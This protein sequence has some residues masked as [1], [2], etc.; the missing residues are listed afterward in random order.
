VKPVRTLSEMIGLTDDRITRI[1]DEGEIIGMS[2]RLV[3]DLDKILGP[4]ETGYHL[5][6]GRP[7]MGKTTLAMSAAMGYALN[8]NPGIYCSAEMT[9][10]Q[11]SM[12]A[13]TDLAF[14]H[15]HKVKHEDLRTG[16]LTPGERAIVRTMMEKAKLIPID[17][18]DLRGANIR[19]VWSEVARRKAY[20]AAMGKTLKFA[21]IDSLALYSADI[22]G[23]TIEDDRKRINFI[24]T[25][26]NTMAHTLDIAV[27]ALNQL[28]RGVE[29]RPNKR[30]LLSD[31]KESGNLEQDADSVTFIYRDEYYLEQSEPKKGDKD[32]KGADLHEAWEV[33]MNIARGKADLIGAK[34]RHGRNKTKTVNFFGAYYAIREATVLDIGADDPLLM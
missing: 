1:Q 10:E 33:E 18:V 31:L 8:G 29:S 27:M 12:R 15:G 9:D 34:N 5:L 16:K 21:V 2:N 3:P 24:S 20:Y 30:P 4:L 28:S 23:R 25:F 32:A 22:D 26:V 17:F 14:A 19:R 7:G 11:L 6:A 13:T